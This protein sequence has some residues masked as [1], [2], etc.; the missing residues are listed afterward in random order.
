MEPRRRIGVVTSSRADYGH[1]RWPLRAMAEHPALEPRLYVTGAHLTGEFGAAVHE[2]E[3][4]GQPIAARVESLLSSDTGAGAAKSLGVATL[5]F[6]DLFAHERPDLLLL[7][8]DRYE[9]L[10]PAVTALTMRIP[11]AHIEGGEISEGAIDDCVRNALTRLAHVHFTTTAE[12]AAR[13]AAHGEEPWRIHL[14]GSPSLDQLRREALPDAVTILRR[15]GLPPNVAPLLVAYH[16]V[17]LA[18][19]PLDEARELLAALTTTEAPI[20][21]CF[22]NADPGSR[23]VLA[24]VEAFCAARAQARLVVNLP[25]LEYLSLLRDA[26]ALVGNSS[27]G[28]MEAASLETPVV[29]VGERQRG[30]VRGGN[31]VWAAGERR[32]I[33][34]AIAHATSAAFRISLRGIVNPY[35]D[36]RAAERIAAALAA[37]RTGEQLLIKRATQEDRDSDRGP[38][39]AVGTA[40]GRRGDRVRAGSV[41]LELAVDHGAARRRARARG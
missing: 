36:G 32:A 29:D 24:E 27:S 13:L 31:I 22:P 10:A 18:E 1:L 5:G 33:A 12:A 40:H 3:R 37:V 14:T 16:P 35:G 19:R 7:I 2:I 41:H 17:T 38:Y 34:H 9:M 39:R 6:A 15:L 28:I 30:R 11:I 26:A 25:S 23:A 20:V 8:A 21:F 4:D